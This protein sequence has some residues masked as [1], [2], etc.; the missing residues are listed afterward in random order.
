MNQAAR[1]YWDT[2]WGNHVQPQ[3]VYAF[4]FGD[5][6]DKL[7]E[8][9]RSGQKTATCTAEITYQKTNQPLPKR[10]DYGIVLNR[11][12]EPVAI[13]KTTDVFT[14]RFEDVTEAFA[15]AEGDGSLE[16]WRAIH[17]RYFRGEYKRLGIS[18]DPK[19]KL[20]CE[21]FICVG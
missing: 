10:D 20:V 17:E 14:M 13:I 19:L 11:L 18:Y 12:D 16:A 2:Y 5:E 9:V 6:P 3:S 1:N 21:R 15:L 8:L 4:Q 7:A